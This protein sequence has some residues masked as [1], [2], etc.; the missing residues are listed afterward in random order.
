MKKRRR[1]EVILFVKDEKQNIIMK[2]HI[3][4]YK[5]MH[6]RFGNI[7]SKVVQGQARPT[8]LFWPKPFDTEQNQIG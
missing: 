3:F 1:S 7:S 6:F 2:Y 5:K 8:M 4:F